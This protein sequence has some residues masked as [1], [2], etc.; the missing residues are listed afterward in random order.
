MRLSRYLIPSLLLFSSCNALHA[1]STEDLETL[2][3]YLLNL[4]ADF[5]FDITQ[6][7][8]SPLATLLDIS[9]STLSQ[10]YAFITLLGAI[11]VNAYQDGMLA[12][13]VPS[14]DKNY[15]AINDMANYT[16]VSQNV[17]YNDPKTGENGGV[18][19]TELIDQADYQNDPVSQSVLNII[20]TP[21]VTYAL[22]N[23]VNALLDSN[24]ENRPKLTNTDVMSNVLGKVPG[25]R[26]FYTYDYNKDIML[27]L[28]SN[29]LMAPLLYANDSY[30]TDSSGLKATNQIQ[31]AVNF[32]RYATRSVTPPDLPKLDEYKKLYDKASNSDG[33]ISDFDKYI[34]TAGISKYITKLRTFSAQ[35]SVAI[36]NLYSILSRR[37]PQ[38]QST[39][40]S[41]QTSQA[42]SEFQMATRRLY[43]PSKKDDQNAKQWID[44]INEASTATVQKEMAILLA[45]MNYQLYLSR[46]QQERMLLTLSVMSMQNVLEPLF[47]SESDIQVKSET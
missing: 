15:A 40:N 8:E 27:Q 16:F 1:D 45:E 42:L 43:D 31:D 35:Q 17:K 44:K 3:E 38:S 32:I 14:N 22:N 46:Q 10:Q 26:D 24:D 28:N 30:E 7:V 33:S 23:D 9:A 12:Y 20:A 25:P 36:G 47:S 2:S 39:D 19:V 21:N 37:M 11:P 29:T 18:S 41:T 6:K 5:G 4:G 13:F 34:A